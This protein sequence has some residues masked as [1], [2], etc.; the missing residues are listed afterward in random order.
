MFF[1][2]HSILYLDACLNL[3]EEAIIIIF[4]VKK[5]GCLVVYEIIIERAMNWIA[6]FSLLFIYMLAHK[7]FQGYSFY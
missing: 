6:Y 5:Q 2:F 3:A 1:T 7:N 4:N